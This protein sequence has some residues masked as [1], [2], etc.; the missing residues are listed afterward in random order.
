[1]NAKPGMTGFVSWKVPKGMQIDSLMGGS[2][3]LSTE[4]DIN[5]PPC[6]SPETVGTLVS[7]AIK[8]LANAKNKENEESRKENS[9]RREDSLL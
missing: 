3:S 7:A 8:E 6:S 9:A 2:A 4:S 5:K 1:M